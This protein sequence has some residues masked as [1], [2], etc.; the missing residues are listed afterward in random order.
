MA[1]LIY[2]QESYDI[3]GAC[4]EVYKGMGRGFLEPVYQE[5]L[6][7]EFKERRIPF[8]PERE[9]QIDYKG[10]ILEQFYKADFVC[11]DKIIVEAKAVTLLTDGHRAHIFN[12][13]RATGMR[14]GLLVNFSSHPKVEY[15]RIIL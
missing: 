6:E 12:Y 5:C 10:H 3:M 15:E 9:L 11:Y 8:V 7:I 1:E 4:F 2:E 14:L 13:L